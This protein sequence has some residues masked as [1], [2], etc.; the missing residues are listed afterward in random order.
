FEKESIDKNQLIVREGAYC[1][2]LL[3]IQEGYLRFYTFTEK[4]D[5]TH[6]IF[7]KEQIVTDVASFYMMEPAKWNIQAL[8]DCQVYAISD[9]HY[10]QLSETF[11]L[12]SR[13]EKQLFVRLLSVLEKRVYSFLS[14]SAEERYQYLY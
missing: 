14:M 2:K 10:K 13:F 5:I 1:K 8:S 7:W 12:W 3:F 6:W 11:P 4:K 9:H